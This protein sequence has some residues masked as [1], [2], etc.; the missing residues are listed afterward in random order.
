MLLTASIIVSFVGCVCLLMQKRKKQQVRKT[1]LYGIEK[2]V[3]LKSLITLSQQ[4]RGLSA[5]LINGNVKVKEQLHRLEREI[6]IINQSLGLTDLVELNSRWKS[7]IDH[8]QRLSLANGNTN[9][10]NNFKQHTNL[11]SNLL[12]LLEDEAERSLLT[13]NT[14]ELLPN[15]GFVWRELIQAAENVGQSRAIG[16]GVATQGVCGD[17][18]QIRLSFLQQ[19]MRDAATNAL[20]QLSCT[21][22]FRIEHRSKIQYALEQ[23]NDLVNIIEKDLVSASKVT[24]DSTVY[25]DFASLTISALHDVFDLQIKQIKQLI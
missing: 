16:T 1:Q 18:D 3:Q 7:F 19:Q 13:S 6:D 17:V 22:D 15:L 10:L 14:I 4:H 24:I 21:E 2:I 5:A 12:Y 11:I 8:W 23:T 25:F 20:N 9:A